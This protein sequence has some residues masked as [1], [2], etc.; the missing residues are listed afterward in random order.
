MLQALKQIEKISKDLNKLDTETA[1]N[2]KEMQVRFTPTS[3]SDSDVMNSAS[4][5]QKVLLN[6]EKDKKNPT[7]AFAKIDLTSDQV[8]VTVRDLTGRNPTTSPPSEES[9]VSSKSE[10]PILCGSVVTASSPQY[11]NTAQSTSPANMRETSSNLNLHLRES[12]S[13]DHVAG[14][15]LLTSSPVNSS[16]TSCSVTNFTESGTDSAPLLDVQSYRERRLPEAGKTSSAKYMKTPIVTATSGSHVQREGKSVEFL[17]T[18]KKYALPNSNRTDKS[19]RNSVS[20]KKLPTLH[21]KLL[22]RN[23]SEIEVK[24]VDTYSKQKPENAPM[25]ALKEGTNNKPKLQKLTK[26]LNESDENVARHAMRSQERLRPGKHSSVLTN[27]Q[28]QH[29]GAPK[30]LPENIIAHSKDLHKDFVEAVEKDD[31]TPSTTL[32]YALEGPPVRPKPSVTIE[33]DASGN[34]LRVITDPRYQM[35]HSPNP[36]PTS[37]SLTSSPNQSRT[38]NRFMHGSKTTGRGPCS[39]PSGEEDTKDFATPFELKPGIGKL[40]KDWIKKKLPF[41]DSSSKGVC[42]SKQN[43]TRDLVNSQSQI[44]SEKSRSSSR[45]TQKVRGNLERSTSDESLDETNRSLGVVRTKRNVKKAALDS[46]ADKAKGSKARLKRYTRSK[47]DSPLEMKNLFSKFCQSQFNQKKPSIVK[48]FE[49]K[50]FENEIKTL[51]E[52]SENCDQSKFG[53]EAPKLEVPET[54]DDGYSGEDELDIEGSYQRKGGIETR[55]KIDCIKTNLTKPS[56]S[57]RTAETIFLIPRDSQQFSPADVVSKPSHHKSMTDIRCSNGQKQELSLKNKGKKVEPSDL[58]LH[59]LPQ[60]KK[61]PS[62]RKNNSKMTVDLTAVTEQFRDQGLSP[63]SEENQTVSDL[64]GKFNKA[65]SV[66]P[67]DSFVRRGPGRYSLTQEN[68]DRYRRSTEASSLVK[69]D[70]GPERRG[71][72]KRLSWAEPLREIEVKGV[73]WRDKIFAPSNSPPNDRGDSDEQRENITTLSSSRRKMSEEMLK[74]KQNL[75][76]VLNREPKKPL[77][78]RYRRSETQPLTKNSYDTSSDES[79]DVDEFARPN[80]TEEGSLKKAN[81]MQNMVG[82]KYFFTVISE[83]YKFINLVKFI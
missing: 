19:A 73:T 67:E 56:G 49:K 31:K 75:E 17:K 10:N 53:E 12:S 48:Q 24:K 76:R 83:F 6:E 37:L 4:R 80:A 47:T 74:K 42:E 20:A 23:P 46:S 32:P 78:R 40:G 30:N 13:G 60:H 15:T 29:L 26:T 44:R 11:S 25:K 59:S 41:L 82:V 54:D 62:T 68:L 39:N 14:S 22:F 52:H 38:T 58:S 8:N 18:E 81:S 27:Q 77:L 71:Q 36:S 2:G 21:Q 3:A 66:P 55:G 65:G 5:I 33:K 43:K 79:S 45:K 70:S 63:E 50:L 69:P 34:V 64:V 72:S 1:P 61:L 28:E 51:Q 9:L 16:T 7:K 35:Q 57:L